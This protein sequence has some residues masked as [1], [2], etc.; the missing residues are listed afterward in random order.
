MKIVAALIKDGQAVDTCT[1]EMPSRDDLAEAATKAFAYFRARYP[2][3]ATTPDDVK[4]AFQDDDRE[5]SA[6]RKNGPVRSL[7]DGM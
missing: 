2:H 6:D 7:C 3:L 1:F 4:V 5:S